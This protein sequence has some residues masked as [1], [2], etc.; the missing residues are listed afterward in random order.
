MEMNLHELKEWI[1][2]HNVLKEK[3]DLLNLKLNSYI[4]S[5]LN[6]KFNP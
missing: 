2:E 4:K 6:K 3:L 5:N 1:Q